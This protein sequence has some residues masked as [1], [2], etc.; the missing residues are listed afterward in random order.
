MM[1]Y[2]AMFWLIVFAHL[3]GEF[4]LFPQSK[5]ALKKTKPEWRLLHDFL[6]GAVVLLAMTPIMSSRGSWKTYAAV[7]FA[8]TA[9]H[10]LID[11]L[12]D[13]LTRTDEAGN[14]RNA[15]LLF[16]CDQLLHAAIIFGAVFIFRV[17]V[18]RPL[19][20]MAFSYFLSCTGVYVFNNGVRLM[21][22]LQWACLLLAL[23]RPADRFLRM[24]HPGGAEN[25]LPPPEAP[26]AVRVF[27]AMERVA[28]ALFMF[29]GQFYAIPIAFAVKAFALR[30]ANGGERGP[31]DQAM[32]RTLTNAL[33]AVA[34]ALLAGAAAPPPVLVETGNLMSMSGNG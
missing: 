17:E 3:I 25:P 21:Q 32:L 6:Y 24:A 27:D 22:V 19:K 33:I 26:R 14:V 30:G 7:W 28:V 13:A 23:I 29:S 8:V 18:G 10:A 15:R 4:Y 5:L 11:W 34:F 12:R 20:S 2:N 31:V 1:L 16:F 9:G